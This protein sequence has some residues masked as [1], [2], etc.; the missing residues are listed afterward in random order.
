M[1][2]DIE[3]FCQGKPKEIVKNPVFRTFL[4]WFERV[5]HM[6]QFDAVK[7]PSI[8]LGHFKERI[9]NLT[10]EYCDASINY[11]VYNKQVLNS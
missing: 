8:W 11:D 9:N 6:M 7:L 4:N 10:Q 2:Y 5:V 1:I 3:V